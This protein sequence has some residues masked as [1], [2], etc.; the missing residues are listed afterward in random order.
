MNNHQNFDLKNTFINFTKQQEEVLKLYNDYLTGV[1]KVFGFDKIQNQLKDFDPNNLKADNI[2]KETNKNM[3]IMAAKFAEEILKNEYLDEKTKKKSKFFS[4]LF[5]DISDPENNIFTNEKI[6]ENF[7]KDSGTT[8]YKG[9]VNLYN[10]FLQGDLKTV[11]REAFKIG[12]NLATTEGKIIFQNDLMQLMHYKPLTKEI[13]EIPLLVIPPFI[14]KYYVLDLSEKNSFVKWLVQQGYSV[15]MISWKNHNSPQGGETSFFDYMEHG[16]LSAIKF[17]QKKYKFNKINTL[18]YCIGGT[19]LATTLAYLKGMNGDDLVNASVFLPTPIDFEEAGAVEALIDEEQ[20]SCAEKYM[21]N[22]GGYF[23][24]KDLYNIFNALKLK[25]TVIRTVINHYLLGEPLPAF[26]V[27]YWNEDS[28]NLPAKM[29][30]F[31]LRN[32]YLENNLAKGNLIHNGI[33]IN[34]SNIDIPVYF[35]ATEDDH[36]TIPKCVFQGM[37]LLNSKEKR[38]ILA[39]SG[40]VMGVINHPSRNKYTYQVI[41]SS[42]NDIITTEKQKGSWWTDLNDWLSVRSGEQKEAH[43]YNNI[44]TKKAIEDAPGS[45]VKEKCNK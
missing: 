44:S 43:D 6:K 13:H 12:H 33:K 38:F 30:S 32:M 28:V 8:F 3:N 11:D 29:H 20:I 17:V 4:K 23:K 42:N 34:M 27:L 16:I 35:L 26:D 22:A 40:H 19:L 9:L 45:Y 7:I 21:E 15:F 36:I 31:Y 10:D 2:L 18:G 37:K 41:D 14:N 1:N 5:L 39:E 24:G 25:D